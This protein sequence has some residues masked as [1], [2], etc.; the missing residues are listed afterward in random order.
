MT[1][2]T[3]NLIGLDG[4]QDVA[5][6]FEERGYLPDEA[7]A[8]VVFLALRMER[9]L[10]LEGEAG[11]GK[12]EV[13]K[14]LANWTGGTL[15]RLQCYDGIDVDQAIYEWDYSRQLL[16]LRATEVA[17]SGALSEASLED[18]LFSERFL[19]RRPLLQ[20]IMT[21]ADS[22]PAPVLL[23]DEIDRGRRRVRGP[24]ARGPLRLH[25]ERAGAWHVLH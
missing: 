15:L 25:S 24:A 3:P 10:F 22:G 7:L 19:V 12:T 18:E 13:A 21:T 14:V 2:G 17:R 16:H 1:T 4:P 5:R 6:A 11:V 20:A 8:T 23:I 9:P